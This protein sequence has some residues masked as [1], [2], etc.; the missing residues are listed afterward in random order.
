M[1][2]YT[3]LMGSILLA[4]ASGAFGADEDNGQDSK[5]SS[6]ALP[7]SQLAAAAAAATGPTAAE[8]LARGY[9]TWLTQIKTPYLYQLGTYTGKGV[10]VGVVDSGVDGNNPSL[11]GQVVQ[12]YNALTNKTGLGSNIAD[13]I[14]H[15]S[16]VSGIIAG[17][18]ANGGL[19]EG[20]APGAQLAMAKVFGA[21]G[22]TSSTTIDA[23]INWLVNTAKAPIISMS[24]G[25]PTAGNLA[26]LQNGVAK[27][28]LFTIATG[29]D[30]ARS[31]SWP[32]AYASATWAKGQIIAVGAVDSNNRLASFSNWCGSAAAN[33]VVA[34]GVNIASTYMAAANGAPQYVYMSGTSMA[35]PMVAGQAALIKSQW[36]FLTAGTIAQVIFKSATHLCS[37]GL[38][39]TA[40]SKV[41][42]PDTQ[43]GWGL[44]NVAA[45]MQPIG[46]LTAPTVKGTTTSTTTASLVSGTTG[47]S[48]AL[49]SMSTVAL[50]SFGRGFQMNVGVASATTASLPVRPY[51]LFSG[52]DRQLSLTE[53]SR[54][55]E[56]LALAYST[57]A[58]LAVS[59]P[60]SP[61]PAQVHMAYSRRLADG[62][63]VGFGMGGMSRHFF[64]LEA[65]GL[66]PLS[67]SQENGR[68]NSPYFNLMREGSHAGYAVSLESG[69]TLRIGTLSKTPA[70]ALQPGLMGLWGDTTRRSLAVFE[71]QK[72]FGADV[73]VAS[74]G[75]L[76]EN[77]SVLG[78][79]GTGALAL[80][81]SPTTTF[82]TLAGA[83][84]LDD[85]LYLAGMVS[86]GRTAAYTNASP[87]ASFIDGAGA[88]STLSWS[89]GVSRRE[90]MR[91]GDALGLTVSMPTKTIAGQLQATTAV[92]QSQLD[93]SLAYATQAYSLRPNASERDV[94]LAY[95]APVG[96]LGK[97]S[98][99]YML[100][101]N[102]GHDNTVPTDKVAGLRFTQRF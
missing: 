77:G 78:S 31:P 42:T 24:L 39:G 34:P 55:G 82:A 58:S 15:G 56:R 57:P 43:Y 29:N 33:C 8:N 50:D 2:N 94:E 60:L 70:V 69:T 37:N 74:T 27:G 14:G 23:G 62:S 99:A 3:I 91:P 30:G 10:L 28:A 54:G 6:P 35:T 83:K 86:M 89:L 87:E 13:Q 32:A 68:F 100:R 64:G 84:R 48:A 45:S 90:W 72:K 44:I 9:Q 17:T 53:E 11:R 1:R 20:V 66:T 26:S 36:N 79:Y 102:P 18:L 7:A 73:I 65:S 98:A 63:T 51:E 59:D 67:L 25:G 85:N 92:T 5:E 80:R 97:F 96:R 76:Q 101:F 49:K 81:A 41:T 12:G 40:C 95:A 61:A 22:S 16:H 38:T 19:L 71:V 47:S 75:V 46:G 88:T 93:G 21:T 52:F 4:C